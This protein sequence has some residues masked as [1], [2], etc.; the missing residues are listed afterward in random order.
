MTTKKTE[1]IIEAGEMTIKVTI[2]RGVWTEEVSLDGMATGTY[3]NHLVNRTTIAL[4]NGKKLMA[5]G[6][7]LQAM[8]KNHKSYKQAVDAGCNVYVGDAWFP[9]PSSEQAIRTALAE[10]EIENPVTAEMAEIVNADA[11]SKAQRDAWYNS[12]EQIAARKFEREMDS[13]NS[14]Y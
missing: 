3:N 7:A 13:A 10:M 14:D 9:K 5:S 11:K 12:D 6:S 8:P 2:E 1:R 4:Y